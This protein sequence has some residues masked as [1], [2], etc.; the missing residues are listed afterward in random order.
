MN[1]NYQTKRLGDVCKS[2]KSIRPSDMYRDNFSY[3]DIASVDPV[4]KSVTAPK[5]LAVSEAPGRARQLVRAGDSLFATTRPYLENIAYITDHLDG[6]I[7][8]TGYCVISPNK[9]LCD[10]KYIFLLISSKVFIDQVLVH[11]KGASYPAVSDQDILN[12]EIPLPPLEEQR[13]IVARIEMQFVKIDEAARLRA[14]AQEATAKLLPAALHEIFS[15]SEA[16]GWEQTTLG[17]ICEIARGGSPRPIQKYLT[18]SPD[19]INWVKISDA[20]NSTKYIYETRQ[21]ITREGLN[22]TRLMKTDGAIHDG[23]L[24]LRPKQ[25]LLEEYM[26]YFLSS[27][28]IY[29]QFRQ[30]AGGAVVQNLNSELVRS[31]RISIPPLAQQKQ[32]VKKLDALSEKVRTLQTLQ[33]T[34]AA[35]LKALKQSLLREAFAE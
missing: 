9:E 25:S 35:D 23:W 7:A 5:K 26:Y 19:G 29:E 32:I 28:D 27:D 22:K 3:I 4:T 12:L 2:V 8:S 33:S 16:K 17:D 20:T 13:K 18:D 24:L 11:Q 21:K 30:L 14:E 10:S 31:V 34:Q 1:T 15:Q 6:A